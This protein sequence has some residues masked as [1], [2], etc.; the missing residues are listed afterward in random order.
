MNG[1]NEVSLKQLIIDIKLNLTTVYNRIFDILETYVDK[2]SFYELIK[3]LHELDIE[4]IE[5]VVR[6]DNE[7]FTMFAGY[8]D[9]RTVEYERILQSKTLFGFAK[10]AE[11]RSKA[12]KIAHEEVLK[13]FFTVSIA[14]DPA[15]REILDQRLILRGKLKQKLSKLMQDNLAFR[16]EDRRV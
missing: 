16:N 4:F 1:Q 2:S 13:L 7:R 5:T 15:I 11:I 3:H 6:I 14:N 12:N 8:I 9:R 10:K